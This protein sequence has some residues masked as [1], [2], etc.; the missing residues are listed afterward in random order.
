MFG[1]FKKKTDE[2]FPSKEAIK[3]ALKHPNGYV[4][5]IDRAFDNSE[6]VPPQAIKGAWKVNEHGFIV[7]QFIPN[8]NYV[9]LKKY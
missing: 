4:Y 3:E 5:A 1:L 9:D 8:P 2:M 7:G 6:E